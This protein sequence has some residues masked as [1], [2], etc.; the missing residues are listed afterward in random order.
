[1]FSL[2]QK[3]RNTKHNNQTPT[4]N[5]SNQQLMKNEGYKQ[6]PQSKK[7]T[8]TVFEDPFNYQVYLSHK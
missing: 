7:I 8:K 3:K 1:M 2:K 6:K 5:D 4:K